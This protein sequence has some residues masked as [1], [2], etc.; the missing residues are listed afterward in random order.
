[1]DYV[2]GRTYG[3]FNW[4]DTRIVV[5]D[6][7]EDK[8]D[9][10]REYSGLNDFTSLR[11]EQVGFLKKELAGKEFR[12]ADKRILF[13]HIPIYGMLGGNLCEPLWRPMLDK[14]PF[15]VAFNAHVHKFAFHPVGSSENNYPVVIGGG[16]GLETATVMVL[17][18]TKGK[19]KVKVFNADGKVLLEWED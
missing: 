18:K 15:D 4:G 9:D 6:C 17:E 19:L 5:L 3:A 8:Q 11:Q 16:K 13:H 1:M 14:A 10:H 12:K 2:G 7:G